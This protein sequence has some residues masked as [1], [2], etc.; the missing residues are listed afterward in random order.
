MTAALLAI[1]GTVV[2]TIALFAGVIWLAE[3]KA[4]AELESE[5]AHEAIRKLRAAVEADV[6]ARE[7]LARG[8]LLNDDGH[9]RD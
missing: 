6:R 3:R 8:E 5:G 9:R 2:A 1:A 7:R 4:R